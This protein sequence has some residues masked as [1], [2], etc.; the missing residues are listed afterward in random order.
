[1]HF[2]VYLVFGLAFTLTAFRQSHQAQC[3]GCCNKGNYVEIN[4]PRRSNQSIWKPGQVALC[5][6]ALPWGWY[7]FNSH[8]GGKMPTTVANPNHCGT[9]APIWL[10]GTHPQ[11]DAKVTVKA[12]VN[13]FNINGGCAQSFDVDIKDCAGNFFVYYLRPTYSCSLAYC[14]GDKKPCPYGKLATASGVC[15]D[16][17]TPFDRSYLGEPRISNESDAG[18][19]NIGLRCDIPLDKAGLSSWRNVSYRIAWYSEGKHLYTEFPCGRL[20]HNSN[21]YD[22]SCP[23]SNKPLF[24]RLNSSNYSLQRRVD[25][26]QRF[27]PVYQLHG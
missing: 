7:R 26:V 5:D 11:N 12:C 14:A 8:V 16:P 20:P 13:F 6:R 19:P 23:G 27:S 10:Q 25:F 3:N 18:T 9:I 17:P 4:E 22:N 2:T 1:M 21:E 15:Y 24:S